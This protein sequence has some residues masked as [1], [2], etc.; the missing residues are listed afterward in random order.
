VHP[1]TAAIVVAEGLA[2]EAGFGVEQ[3]SQPGVPEVAVRA[4]ALSERTL[5]TIRAD[6]ARALARIQ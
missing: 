6:A 3:D 4:L 5:A 1:L 2:A